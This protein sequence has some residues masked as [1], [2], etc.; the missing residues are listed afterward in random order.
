MVQMKDKPS[1]DV[2]QRIVTAFYAGVSTRDLALQTSLSERTIRNYRQ[3]FHL[4]GSLYPPKAKLGRPSK[5]TSNMEEVG[6]DWR[7]MTVLLTNCIGS[8]H[9]SRG[10]TY[11]RSMGYA[12]LP[13]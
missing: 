9:I 13:I 7:I 1:K 2:R 6:E 8:V 3:N 12:I 10:S 11:G 4:H 5:L